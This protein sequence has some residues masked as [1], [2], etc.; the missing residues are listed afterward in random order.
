MHKR[1]PHFPVIK[2]SAFTAAD[3][4]LTDVTEE[5]AIPEG[6][7]LRVDVLISAKPS[8]GSGTISLYVGDH[9]DPSDPASRMYTF[10]K[11]VTVDS[12]NPTSVPGVR[13]ITLNPEV[14]GD[15]AVLPLPTHGVIKALSSGDVGATFTI[16]KVCLVQEV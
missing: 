14:A 13:V 9:M 10:A 16:L 4:S 6:S 15:Q 2:K 1:R 5:F 11:S 8:A 7:R 3:T 12:S